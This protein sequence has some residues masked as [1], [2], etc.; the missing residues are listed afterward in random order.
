M[1]PVVIK[2]EMGI[3]SILC[4]T[5]NNW[6]VYTLCCRVSLFSIDYFIYITLS[7]TSV[8]LICSNY[9]CLNKEI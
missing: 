5:V 6:I 3:Y 7:V 1:Q 8:F 2:I 4:E 9:F